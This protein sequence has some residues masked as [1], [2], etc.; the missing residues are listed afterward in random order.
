MHNLH[1]MVVVA[2]SPEAAC[3]K[4]QNELNGWGDCDNWRTMIGCVSEDGEPYCADS[5]MWKSWGEGQ[6]LT[7]EWLV[8]MVHG[9]LHVNT[10]DEQEVKQHMMSWL[11]G[12]ELQHMEWYEISDFC[13]H[14]SDRV[15]AINNL[16]VDTF[17]L[18]EDEFHF[19]HYDE[20]GVTHPEEDEVGERYAVLFDMHS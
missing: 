3:I 17:N 19:G 11:A 10:E 14:Q 12:K 15:D 2:E 1:L 9:W 16:P 18:F 7:L 20:N 5:E 4:V 13:L 8:Q 6:E